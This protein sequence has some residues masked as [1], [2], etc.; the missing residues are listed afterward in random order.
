MEDGTSESLGY[1][2][3][4]DDYTARQ[5]DTREDCDV[6]QILDRI[7]DK[8]SL[9]TIA[10][11]AGRTMRFTELRRE[12]DGVSQRM[13]TRTLRHLERDGLVRRT[14]YPVVPPRVDYELTPLGGS[15]HETI[16]ALVTWTETHQREIAAARTAYD[17]RAEIA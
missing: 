5:W 8:W 16:Q 1:C 4:T 17:S 7:A 2:A 13:L 6:R 12:I 15:L 9:L 10:L 11:L 14:V 3:D